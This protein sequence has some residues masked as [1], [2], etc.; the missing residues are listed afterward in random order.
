[1]LRKTAQLILTISIAIMTQPIRVLA[2]TDFQGELR[3]FYNKIAVNSGANNPNQNYGIEVSPKFSKRFSSDFKFLFQAKSNSDFAAKDSSDNFQFTEKNIYLDYSPSQ[4]TLKIGVQTLTPDGPDVVNP[5]DVIHAKNYKN[6]LNPETIGS[7]GVS[8]TQDLSEF[9]WQIFLIPKQTYNRLPGEKS[10]WWPREKRLP[11][12]SAYLSEAVIPQNMEY[13][14]T[15]GVEIDS[16]SKANFLVKAQMIKPAIE[17]AIIY[18]E[19]LAQEPKL[20]LSANT[21]NFVLDSPVTLIPFYF[22]HRVVAASWSMPLSS[23]NFTGGAN[24]MKPMGTDSRLPGEESTA[25]LGIEKNQE[26][27]FGMVTWLVEYVTQNRQVK[28]QVSFL[29]SI[30][31]RA[32]VLGVRLPINE[33]HEILTGLTY[34]TIGKSSVLK[35]NYKY[36]FTDSLSMDLT[37]QQ[38]QGPDSSMVGLYKNYDQ[39]GCGLSYN[40]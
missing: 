39:Y 13:H 2:K 27:K 18:Y 7:V 26:F 30:F 16:A 37:T 36:R 9:S 15:D 17:S 25:V 10:I 5:M 34:D 22:R 40:F 31:E 35:F 21:T 1:M 8:L 29:R 11:I 3:L 19:G 4:F 32:W 38:L 33:K 23:F 24:W 14:I 12:E 20:F 6:P 28:D